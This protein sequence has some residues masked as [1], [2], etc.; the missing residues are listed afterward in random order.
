MSLDDPRAVRD[1]ESAERRAQARRGPPPLPGLPPPSADPRDAQIAALRRQLDTVPDV[2][3]A[4]PSVPP[5]TDA[6]LGRAFRALLGKALAAAL[7]S[8]LGGGAVVLARPAA[9]PE[10]VEATAE[11]VTA[12]ER[13]LAAT[14]RQVLAAEEYSRE[15]ARIATCLR[16]QQG[17]V[18][19]AAQPAPDRMRASRLAQPWVDVCP[20]FP[21]PP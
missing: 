11:R 9:Q 8:A 7:A 5:A 20:E 1:A 13:E 15:L 16:R 14:R 12:A 17:A 10:R 6:A 4:P 2:E 18:N 3:L 21:R 19:E